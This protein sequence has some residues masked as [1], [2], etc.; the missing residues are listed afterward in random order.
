[1]RLLQYIFRILLV[2]ILPFNAF[3]QED[4]TS[5]A[6]STINQADTTY[7]AAD[8]TEITSDTT[9]IQ[10]RSGLFL[11]ID[12]GKLATAVSD[13]E[14]KFEASIGFQLSNRLAPVLEIGYA[15]L[16]PRTAFENG[17]YESAGVYGRF[18]IN[19]LIPLDNINIYYAGLRYGLSSYEDE[20]NY[21]IESDIF[22]TYSV[23]FGES[24]QTAT[25]FEIVLGSEKK[26]RNYNIYL[27]GLFRLRF[28]NTRDKFVPIDTYS[29]PGYG[30]TLDKSVPALN[31][32]VKYLF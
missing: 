11:A 10:T 31:L 1:M 20:G 21:I 26:I 14:S 28:I 3:A 29:I 27:G 12:Y 15:I 24:N 19:Y 8:S 13:F 16:N 4:S 18:G 25:W 23:D 22:E 30:R 32:Y 17:T 2:A 6:D 9:R 5:V 7:T